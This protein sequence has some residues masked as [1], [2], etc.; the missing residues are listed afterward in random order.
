M[1]YRQAV[2]DSS[3]RGGTLRPCVVTKE[4]RDPPLV[5][6]QERDLRDYL[7]GSYNYPDLGC[8]ELCEH[9]YTHGAMVPVKRR[10][11]EL[12]TQGSGQ[13]LR[14]NDDGEPPM[15]AT[16]YLSDFLQAI[17]NSPRGGL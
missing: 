4:D 17:S 3:K 8:L 2:D 14:W 15:M 5:T 7:G 13:F 1:A 16:M 9:P 6:M 10:M 12:I 11:E